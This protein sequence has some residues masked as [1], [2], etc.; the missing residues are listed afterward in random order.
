MW[1]QYMKSRC[2]VLRS[3]FHEGQDQPDFVFLRKNLAKLNLHA[4]RNKSFK[5]NY[6]RL[7]L[8]LIW[9]RFVGKWR[10]D[11]ESSCSKNSALLSTN[12][13]TVTELGSNH[14]W[15]V[16]CS[17]IC[18]SSFFHDFTFKLQTLV[19]LEYFCL[20]SD[21]SEFYLPAGDLLGFS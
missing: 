11:I 6:L 7:I 20:K 1:Y 9:S 18:A 3:R 2:V 14:S 15:H 21:Q 12:L 17:I 16:T 19:G 13:A 5:S 8:V 10:K 4:F